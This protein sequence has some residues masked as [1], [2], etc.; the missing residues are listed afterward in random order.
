MTRAKQHNSSFRRFLAA[1]DSGVVVSFADEVD[2]AAA[3]LKARV[4]AERLRLGDWPLAN[5][6]QDIIPGLNNVLIQYDAIQTSQDELI[7]YIAGILPELKPEAEIHARRWRI[8][9]L[10][11][12][13]TGPDL[14][15]VA[16]CTGLT[17]D[18]VVTRHQ[19]LPLTV[20]IMGFM[21]GLGYMKG[22]DDAL[23]LPRRSSP[24]KHVP[25][26]SLGIAMDQTVIYPMDSPGGWNLIGKVPMR[27][28]DQS[29]DDPVLFRPGDQV[30]FA[31]V[32]AEEFADLE[33][34][35][36]AGE[37]IVAPE[38]AS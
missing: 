26:R 23:H 32:S 37:V 1:A 20:A 14:E 21:P 25:A 28:F 22:V 16:A 24:R 13:G 33:A 38:V 17:P 2:A 31:S 10:Y 27:I 18:E 7:K 5:A 34:R 36:E 11:G 35:A 4:L 8:P 12:G 19:A 29:R 30:S 9:V 15:E 6:V 3:M